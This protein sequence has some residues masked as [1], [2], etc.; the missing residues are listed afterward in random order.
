MILPGFPGKDL[1]QHGP[2]DHIELFHHIGKL[3]PPQAFCHVVQAPP[4]FI[5]SCQKL[6]L[7][8]FFHPINLIRYLFRHGKVPGLVEKYLVRL[9]LFQ[10]FFHIGKGTYMKVQTVSVCELHQPAIAVFMVSIIPEPFLRILHIEPFP[11]S[12]DP[13]PIFDKRPGFLHHIN[14]VII[15]ENIF[16]NSRNCPGALQI[17]SQYVFVFSGCRNQ[18]I[19]HFLFTSHFYTSFC[20]T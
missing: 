9:P 5:T 7:G 17:C 16:G 15:L 13:F 14:Q 3:L 6:F 10:L 12:V 1:K 18:Q 8:R 20:K 19:K 4:E 2:Y 11:E